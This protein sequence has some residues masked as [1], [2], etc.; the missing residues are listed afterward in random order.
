MRGRFEEAAARHS[1]RLE[2]G[3]RRASVEIKVERQYEPLDIADSAPVVA[4]VAGAVRGLGRSFKTRAT[5]GGSDA[6]VYATRGI[7][8]ANLGCGMRDIH[9]VNEWVDLKDLHTTASIVLETVRL[10]AVSP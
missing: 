5:G 7:E 6:N 3:E 2:Q 8:V 1:V 4:L 9:T 10:N